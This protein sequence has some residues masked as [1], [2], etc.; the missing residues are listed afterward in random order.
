MTAPAELTD[1]PQVK[2]QH[3]TVTSDFDDCEQCGTEHAG[4]IGVYWDAVE[5]PV[6][7]RYACGDCVI[8]VV[9]TALD[10]APTDST[11]IVEYE[12]HAAPLALGV[13]A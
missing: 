9:R 2:V 10:D 6:G 11:V 12:A 8:A 1:G 7:L 4:R 13:A 5:E 3:V